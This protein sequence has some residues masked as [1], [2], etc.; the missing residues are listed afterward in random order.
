MAVTAWIKLSLDIAW[1]WISLSVLRAFYH[2]PGSYWVIIN[3]VM[4]VNLYLFFYF[5]RW[6]GLTIF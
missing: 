3:R 4:Q 1:A 2:P 6:E 5:C